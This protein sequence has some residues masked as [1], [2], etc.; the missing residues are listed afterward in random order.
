MLFEVNTPHES[1]WLQRSKVGVRRTRSEPVI[2]AA[3]AE[4]RQLEREPQPPDSKQ[5][6]HECGKED[7][8]PLAEP[9]G[10]PPAPVR[11]TRSESAMHLPKLYLANDLSTMDAWSSA[12]SRL[13]AAA[14][15]GDPTQ[16]GRWVADRTVT[17]TQVD[18]MLEL[19]KMPHP[20]T[21]PPPPPPPDLP[22]ITK[23]VQ[24]H[25]H[26]RRQMLAAAD[27]FGSTKCD[28]GKLEYAAILSM[29]R[30]E[31]TSDYR[32]VEKACSSCGLV[33]RTALQ[34]KL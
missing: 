16:Q 31:P 30:L 27:A 23:K 8:E 33:N 26:Q 1:Y 2:M 24:Q 12:R 17:N 13:W 25:K 20:P 22:L 32:T 15:A 28:P 5:G 3:R 21:P 7:R 34:P 6:G 11:K 14:A 9:P 10:L 4:L 29:L 19:Q 18:D